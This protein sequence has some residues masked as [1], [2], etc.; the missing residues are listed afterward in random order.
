MN[1]KLFILSDLRIIPHVDGD[2][3]HGIKAS[4]F[5]YKSFGEAYF[6][7]IHQNSTKGWKKHTQMTMN[8]V[9]P[10]GSISFFIHDEINKLT[11]RTT[12]G[13]DNYKRLTV[14]PGA[15]L[16]FKG[17]YSRNI[18]LNIADL[19]HN[20]SEAINV[21]LSSYPQSPCINF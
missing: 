3:M 9:V 4:D 10:V 7:S 20:P 1:N 5:T 13:F 15:W 18:L 6:S 16:A 21:P 2:I 17:L 8:I 12:I 14:Y 11:Y 19:E